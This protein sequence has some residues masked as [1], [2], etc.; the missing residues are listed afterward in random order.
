MEILEAIYNFFLKLKKKIVEF[1]NSGYEIVRN[2][3]DDFSEDFERESLVPEREHVN[4]DQ[5]SND[6]ESEA[7]GDEDSYLMRH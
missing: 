6:A 4:L 2:T 7:L 1:F 3:Q 5:M